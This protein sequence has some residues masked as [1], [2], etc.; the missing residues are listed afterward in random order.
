MWQR[1]IICGSLLFAAAALDEGMPAWG[2]SE[3]TPSCLILLLVLM[4]QILRGGE[5]VFW[6]G[7][8]GLCQNLL[9]SHPPGPGLMS[10]ATLGL[11]SAWRASSQVSSSLLS[12][13][14]MGGLGLFIVIGGLRGLSVFHADSPLSLSEIARGVLVQLAAT[15]LFYVLICVAGGLVQRWTRRPY[16]LENSCV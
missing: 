6:S 13:R 4:C 14:L 12:D 7:A 1:G 9:W 16:R 2:W 5:L 3:I 8:V 15:Y 10:A 11:F